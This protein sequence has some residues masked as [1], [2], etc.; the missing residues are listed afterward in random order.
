MHSYHTNTILQQE[1]QSDKTDL[2]QFGTN[3]SRLIFCRQSK[4]SKSE[5][6]EE[7]LCDCRAN[8]DWYTSSDANSETYKNN[9]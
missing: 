9:N 1:V 2:L 3:L 7:A 6:K 5:L 8:D 4:I